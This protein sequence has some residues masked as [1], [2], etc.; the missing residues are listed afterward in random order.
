MQQAARDAQM[1]SPVKA[2]E[3]ITECSQAALGGWR[4]TQPRR[5]GQIRAVAPWDPTAPLPI[6]LLTAWFSSSL[7]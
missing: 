7:K 2:G 3:L 1:T 6:P 4:L 5:S